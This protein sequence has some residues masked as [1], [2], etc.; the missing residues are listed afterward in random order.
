M[1]KYSGIYGLGS[2]DGSDLDPVKSKSIYGVVF[3]DRTK[4]QR[5]KDF[6]GV[7]RI[8]ELFNKY[9]KSNA[10]KGVPANTVVPSVVNKVVPAV[11]TGKAVP[12]EIAHELFRDYTPINI[13]PKLKLSLAV[14]ILT[15]AAL[16]SGYYLGR[17]NE[18]TSGSNNDALLATLGGGA[19]GATLGSTMGS[20]KETGLGGLVGA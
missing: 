4:M 14:G 1:Y 12:K 17:S 9:F 20:S 8:K 18:P 19:L 15:L 13:N 5:M 11:A 3:D 7:K 2:I 16:G 10:A 6:I